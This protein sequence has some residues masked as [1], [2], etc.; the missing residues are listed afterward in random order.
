MKL[1]Y[2]K[3][4][5]WFFLISVPLCVIMY[6]YNAITVKASKDQALFMLFLSVALCVIFFYR[7]NNGVI[8]L[9][10]GRFAMP[11][12]KDKK[13]VDY[14]KPRVENAEEIK[15]AVS[16]GEKCLIMYKLN[17][18]EVLQIYRKGDRLVVHKCFPD[19][20]QNALIFDFENAKPS[21]GD[22][23]IPINGIKSVVFGISKTNYDLPVFSIIRNNKN[24]R[25]IGYFE[26]VTKELLTEF[27][28]D[29]CKVKTRNG[30]ETAK[31]NSV[32]AERTKFSY[33]LLHFVTAL[34]APCMLAVSVIGETGK[35]RAIASVYMVIALVI[36]QICLLIVILNRNKLIVEY[37][38]NKNSTRELLL[39]FGVINIALFL[40]VYLRNY[41][42]NTGYFIVLAAVVFAV[43]TIIY[44]KTNPVKKPKKDETKTDKEIRILMVILT[45][46]VIGVSSANLLLGA[47]YVIPVKTTTQ[48][49]AIKEVEAD[50]ENDDVY[51][52][53]VNIDGRN[54][55]VDVSKETVEKNSSFLKAAKTRGILGIEY[56]K[57][58]GY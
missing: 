24:Y 52:V 46:F 40:A 16:Y 48:Q 42:V 33:N 27:F 50:S 5:P 11:S 6:A 55:T 28:A 43:L 4:N 36:L 15:E 17:S 25:F 2:K 44:F 54:R 9:L 38:G 3:I 13:F 47:N 22:W 41:I 12:K 29:I 53:T 49:Y 26:P 35:T 21:K 20:E 7:F 57:T 51:F 30:E 37:D 19:K 39:E 56:I 14:S 1:D 8:A 18:R 10:R 58:E 34:I 23:Y 31:R 45:V 32:K